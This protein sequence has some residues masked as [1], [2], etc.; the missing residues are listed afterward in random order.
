MTQQQSKKFRIV[1]LGCRTNQYEAQAYRDQLEAMGYV[2]AENDDAAEICVVNTCTV[3]AGAD[4]DSRHEIRKLARQNPNTRLVVTGCSAETQKEAIQ[5]I[6]GVT[7]VVLNKDKERL[8]DI[9]FPEMELL[10]EFSIKNFDGHT[11]SFVKVQD[12]C[13]SF[14]T[15]CIIPYVRGRSRSRSMDDVLREV[16]A[17][18]A[19]G[20]KE[21]VL[22]GIN[23]GDFDGAKTDHPDRLADLVRA[24]DAIP[25]LERLRISSIDPDEVDD[26]LID[27]VLN[28]KNTCHS[29]HIVLQSGS[30]VILKRMNR[31]YTRQIFLDT[32]ERLK[33]ASPDFT[34]TTDVIVGFPGETEADFHD[35]LT[36]LQEVCFA[37]VHMFPFSPRPRTRAALMPNQVPAELM[38]ERKQQLIRVAEQQAFVLRERFVGRR[39]SVLTEQTDANHPGQICGHT[40]NFLMVWLPS[41]NLIPNEIVEVELVENSPDGLIGKV[42]GQQQCC[43]G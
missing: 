22:T 36:V 5:S 39:M 41:A 1:S 32:V 14:C 20:F 12:G 19:N 38:R 42:V 16:E 8:L 29:F 27:A 40:E 17:L 23:I 25:G 24:V 26:N 10:P 30:N 15:Y 7:D 33:V 13:N 37:K 18:I 34:M 43:T 4:K 11:R 21:V 3:T 6:E 2:A 31:K 28:G 35:T 9:V